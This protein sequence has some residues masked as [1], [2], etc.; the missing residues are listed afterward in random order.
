MEPAECWEPQPALT[1]P[2][3]DEDPVDALDGLA[4]AAHHGMHLLGQVV[5]CVQAEA[6]LLL[7]LLQGVG[8][9]AGPQ[10]RAVLGG[11]EEKGERERERERERKRY[12]L[13]YALCI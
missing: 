8:P 2:G 13:I 5:L 7:E 3:G 11:G 12:Q 9:L 4:D 10:G 6:G 1:Q